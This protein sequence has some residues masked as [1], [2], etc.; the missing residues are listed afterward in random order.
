MGRIEVKRAGHRGG[1]TRRNPDRR[2]RPMVMALEG[3]ALLSTLTVSSTNDSGA[4]SLRAAVAQANSDN[5]GD[6]I[7]FS[8]LFNTGRVTMSGVTI[9]NNRALIGGNVFNTTRATLHWRRTSLAHQARA[10]V[11]I[12]SQERTSWVASK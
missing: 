12:P 7:V 10:R 2:L 11:S 6:T 8:S 9:K 1:V 5:G 3:R 4:G